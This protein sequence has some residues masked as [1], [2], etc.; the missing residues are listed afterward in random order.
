MNGKYIFDQI[1]AC[2]IVFIYKIFIALKFWIIYE[3][4]THCKCLLQVGN[5]NTNTVKIN[6]HVL[7]NINVLWSGQRNI[8][9]QK[10]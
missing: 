9:A 8:A 2:K 3:T 4:E 6:I 7:T 5:F 10:I 1:F